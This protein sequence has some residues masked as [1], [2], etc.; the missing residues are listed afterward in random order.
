MIQDYVVLDLETTGLSPK[1]DRIIEIGAVRVRQGKVEEV[2]STFVNPGRLLTEHTIEL[3]GIRDENLLDAPLIEDVLEPF[4]DFIGN[5]CLLGHNIL[6]DYSFVKKAAVN[7]KLSFEKDGIDT[8]RIA[9][10]FLTQVPSKRL[11]DL[12]G[13]YNI[14]ITAHRALGDALATHALYGRLCDEFYEKEADTFKP[15]KLIFSVKKESP[16]TL[17]QKE[18]LVRLC[19]RYAIILKEG[20]MIAPIEHVTATWIDMNTLTRNEASRLYDRVITV[21]GGSRS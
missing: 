11:G 4:L 10:R 17:K 5:D 21:Y 8:L 20:Q 14:P 12:C 2:Y 6:F 15:H 9:R 1:S 19:D 7:H 16:I 13:Y 18:Q 3:T